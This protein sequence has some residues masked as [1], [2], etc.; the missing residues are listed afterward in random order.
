[1]SAPI[2]IV[3]CAVDYE[4]DKIEGVFYDRERAKELQSKLKEKKWPQKDFRVEKW[5][6]GDM[7]GIPTE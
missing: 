2:Y 6:D 1:M 7:E 4:G 3:I 5:K